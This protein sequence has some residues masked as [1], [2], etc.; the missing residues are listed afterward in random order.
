[1]LPDRV[2]HQALA[3]SPV[4]G[5]KCGMPIISPDREGVVARQGE[6]HLTS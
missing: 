2:L 1:M 6:P 5:H 3:E 4:R